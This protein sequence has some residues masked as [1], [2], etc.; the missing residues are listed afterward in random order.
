MGAA[1]AHFGIRYANDLTDE[2][3]EYVVDSVDLLNAQLAPHDMSFFF[4]TID[5]HQQIIGG[6]HC[7]DMLGWAV[8]NGLVPD[9][10]PIWLASEDEKLESYNSYV[11]AKWEDRDGKP[12]AA[13]DGKLPEEA[14]A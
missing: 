1:V 14:Y 3:S 10:E 2:F 9:F 6:K 4:D 5:V 13:I 7:W 12:Y 11:C 8:P